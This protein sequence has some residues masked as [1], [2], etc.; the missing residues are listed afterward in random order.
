M[1]PSRLCDERTWLPF[2]FDDMPKDDEPPDGLDGLRLD[3]LLNKRVPS[4]GRDAT[5]TLKVMSISVQYINA[6]I[7]SEYCQREQSRWERVRDYK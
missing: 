5:M 4:T 1:I 3:V 2:G 7:L 6:V